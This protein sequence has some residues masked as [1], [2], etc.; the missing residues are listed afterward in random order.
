MRYI[1]NR[2]QSLIE[3]LLYGQSKKPNKKTIKAL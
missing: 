2:V 1:C 3:T